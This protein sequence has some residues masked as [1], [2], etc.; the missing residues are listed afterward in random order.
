MKKSLKIAFTFLRKGG[1]K[2]LVL[3][4]LSGIFSFLFI[5]L[6]TKTIGNLLAGPSGTINK[7]QLITFILTILLFI[8]TRRTLAVA[9][10]NLSQKYFWQLRK[11]IIT[12]VLG[13]NYAQLKQNK[14][15]INAAILND[16]H[17]LTDAS[18]NIIT[19]STSLIMGIACLGY[20]AYLSLALFYLTAAVSTVG[21]MIYYFSSRKNNKEFDTARKLE[22]DFVESF[23]A[24]LNGFKEIFME[25]KKGE[26]L[27]KERITKI[28]VQAYQNNV[29]AFTGLLNNQIIGQMLFYSLICAVLLIFSVMLNININAVVSFV[30]TLLYLLGAIETVMVLLPGLVRARISSKHLL[31]LRKEL[32]NEHSSRHIVLNEENKSSFQELVIT[33]LTFNYTQEAAKFKIGPIDFTVNRGEVIFIYGGNG[34]GKTTFINT[35]L[36]L[37][38][39]T[40]GQTILNKQLVTIE[41][42][43]YYK[44]LF[45]VVFSDFYL[46]DGLIG[47]DSYDPDKW[48]YYL[49]LFEIEDKVK[50]EGGVFSSTNLSTGQRKRLALVAALL[51]NKPILVLDEWAADQDPAFRKKFYQ[52]IIPILKLDGLSIIAITHDDKY[53]RC[54]DKLFKMDEGKL[55]EEHLFSSEF[56]A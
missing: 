35:L 2:Y 8:W 37:L 10:I 22:N 54:A 13:S 4:L 31:A 45:A 30:F 49:K 51:E 39:P 40:T 53:Y 15:R 20:L 26:Y 36:G 55:L 3:S 17:V 7:G 9:I 18:I 29:T 43:P 6:V 24:I 11:E 56:K 27:Y 52:E 44:S 16:V 12:S 48:S 5:N 28:A 46:F 1:T 25:P 38:Q 33:D 34:S 42:Y 50:L 23:N 41:Q 21:I 19:F 32:A 14:S 47:L